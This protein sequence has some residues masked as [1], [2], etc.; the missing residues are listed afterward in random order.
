MGFDNE[1]ILN[2]QSL[3]G[4]YFCPVCRLLVYPN[5]ALQS[6]CTHLYCK[7][8]LAYIAGSTKACPYDGYLVTEADSKP[9]IDSNKALAETINKIPVHCLFHR[10][11]C[12]WQGPLS[13]CVTH[14]AGCAFGNSPVV[15]NRCGIQIVHRQVQEHAQS[16]PGVHP[17]VQPAEGSQEASG[18]N[19]TT[20]GQ[21]Q[22]TNQAGTA[23]SQAPE[24]Q[25]SQ[26]V[27]PATSSQQI[28]STSLVQGV[29]QA[30][31]LT[32]E[33][34]YQHQQQNYHQYYQQYIGYDPYQQQYQQYYPYQQPAILQTQVYAQPQTQPQTQPQSQSQPQVQPQPLPQPHTQPKGQPQAQ[35]QVQPQVFGQLQLQPHAQSQNPQQQLQS[36]M[37]SQ[38]QVQ[39]QVQ[40]SQALLYPQSQSQPQPQYPI[41]SHSQ[42]HAQVPQHQQLQVQAQY[43]HPLTQP[44]VPPQ[45]QLQ[46]RP[47]AQVQ[48]HLPT[49]PGSQVPPPSQAHLHPQ[50]IQGQSQTQ[51]PS[52]QAVTGYQSYP[53]TQPPPQAPQQHIMNVRPHQQAQQF[54]QMQGQFPQP[55]PHMNPAPQVAAPKQQQQPAL[56]PSPVQN[57]SIP[58]GQQ[59]QGIYSHTQQP[60]HPVPQRAVIPPFQLPMSQQYPTQQ[61]SSGGQ[62]GS[63][64]Q[65]AFV[66]Q[67]QVQ[68]HLRPHGPP[69]H[70]LQ[71]QFTMYP[72]PQQSVGRPNFPN[73]GI[74]SQFH[75]QSGVPVQFKST[76]AGFNHNNLVSSH[77]QVQFSLEQQPG[78]TISSV[79][80]QRPD[81]LPQTGGKKDVVSSSGTDSSEMKMMRSETEAKHLDDDHKAIGE[82]GESNYAD[83]STRE[84]LSEA[85]ASHD[86]E[87]YVKRKVKGETTE[88]MM[89]SSRG[90]GAILVG[91][92]K[93]GSGIGPISEENVAREEKGNMDSSSRRNSLVQ[94]TGLQPNSNLV[95]QRSGSDGKVAPQSGL[96][97]RNLP[98]PH[99][100]AFAHGRDDPRGFPPPGN[101][102]TGGSL[103]P[104]HPNQVVDQHRH[105]A[106]QLPHGSSF[107]HRPSAPPMLQQPPLGPPQHPPMPGH[108]VSHHG[109]PGFGNL[110]PGQ[111][112]IASFGRGQGQFG[113]QSILSDGMYNQGPSAFGPARGMAHK[114]PNNLLEAENFPNQRPVFMDGR[115]TDSNLPRNM[116]PVFGHPS[117]IQSNLL[118]MGQPPGFDSAFKSLPD[119]RF[120]RQSM[121][122]SR[123]GFDRGAF[124]EDTR[125]FRGPYHLDAE[126]V[127]KYGGRFSSG[128]PF[129][130]DPLDKEFRGFN[131]D[132]GPK[133]A[134]DSSRNFQ[135][136]DRTGVLGERA[137]GHPEDNPGRL[138]ASFGREVFEALPSQRH[139][140]GLTHRS[141]G[142]EYSGI[143]S[144]GFE[145]RPGVQRNPPDDSGRREP[146]VYGAGSSFPEGRFPALPSHFHKSQFEDTRNSRMGEHLR[147]GGLSGDD[148]MLSHVRKGDNFGSRDLPTQIRMGEPGG[149]GTFN[150]HTRLGEPVGLESIRGN[151]FGHPRFGETGFRS[152]FPLQGHPNDGKYTGDLE[153]FENSRKRKAASMG[154]CRI[155]KVDCETVEGLDL[156]SQTREHQKIAMDMV[157]SIK[158]QNA[159]KQKISSSNR[160][161][162]DD[163]SKL[164][165]AG[166][167][168]QENKH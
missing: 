82:P 142:R 119:E 129:T 29:G 59:Q 89:E 141:P 36:N 57:L 98:Q 17:Q 80:E 166:I 32:P 31:I 164:K 102:Q 49:Q 151:R 81:L 4:E 41:L 77:N 62:S 86:A 156:H 37:P 145:G 7:P 123:R 139:K 137:L 76:Q 99:V 147:N 48:H 117:E 96:Q 40:P 113:P 93:D 53:Q 109:P 152:S 46:Q 160:S 108:S 115:Q 132:N 146:R 58:P 28:S 148:F 106:P 74:P 2:I 116:E 94:E 127:Q 47:V 121:G 158:Q 35:T 107:Q 69:L 153:S 26:T 140:D 159:K 95:P 24:A 143:P 135:S 75:S 112:S 118:R 124:E 105:Q 65:G 157:R 163:S 100:T 131:P 67:Q 154:W 111:G 85:P 5:E 19:T 128:S 125:G 55:S 18:T 134:A 161:S 16:C 6:Q 30:A 79:S 122:P 39:A 9:L 20:S 155:C 72:Q 83:T 34:W 12:T 61:P 144:H 33:Q 11:G 56:L 21:G 91:D 22:S 54:N 64:H 92:Q 38:L 101:V 73:Q 90:K 120:N 87:Y 114:Q 60:G 42:P 168:G 78:A 130:K 71:P 14:C 25:T 136:Y 15:C 8:C 27:T 97:D 126:A 70:P 165:N 104:S 1:C 66:Q 3:A 52:A 13:E 43:P 167:E 103:Q 23:S 138:G 44:Q 45:L 133:Y 149:V 10:S 63:V 110:P 51:H 50:V 68:S 84:I 150:S 88:N 162:V